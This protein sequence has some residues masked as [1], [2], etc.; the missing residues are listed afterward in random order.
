[1]Y[2]Q[3]LI[4]E[5]KGELG[6]NFENAV[7]GLMTSLPNFYAKEVHDAIAGNSLYFFYAFIKLIEL[8]HYN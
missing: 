1:M 6:G 8:L 7:V 5:L 2:F 4:D 3:D